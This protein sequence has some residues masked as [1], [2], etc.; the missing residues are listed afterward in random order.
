L[1]DSRK[2]EKCNKIVYP[3]PRIEDSIKRLADPKYFTSTDLI[4]GFGQ[5]RYILMTGSALP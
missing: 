1:T 2:L 3:L 5:I 4:K